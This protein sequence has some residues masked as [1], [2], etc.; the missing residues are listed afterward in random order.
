[1]VFEFWDLDFV[2]G[3]KHGETLVAV[4]EEVL[5]VF[6]V[7]FEKTHLDLKLSVLLEVFDNVLQGLVANAKFRICTKDGVG[8]AGTCDAVGQDGGVIA[9]E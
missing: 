6:V 1:M 4:G 2:L 3:F 8:F 7:D 5:N 9:V